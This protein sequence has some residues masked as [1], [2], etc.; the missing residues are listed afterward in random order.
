MKQTAKTMKLQLI[1]WHTAFLAL[2]LMA[3]SMLVPV[4]VVA[5]F[6]I[7]LESPAI[8]PSLPQDFGSLAGTSAVSRRVPIDTV[9]IGRPR[10]T[11]LRVG[12]P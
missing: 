4:N 2:S 10:I 12:W 3:G 9:P 8:A 11:H 1:I 6:P 5:A 7:V